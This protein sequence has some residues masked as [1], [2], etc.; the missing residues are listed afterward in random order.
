MAR[1]FKFTQDELKRAW[2]LLENHRNGRDA[3]AAASFILM[4]ENGLTLRQA[5]AVFRV[6]PKT[7]SQDISKIRKGEV[8]AGKVWGG[9]NNR[10]MT[11]EEEARFLEGF[12][13]KARAGQSMTLPELHREYNARVGKNTPKSTFYRMIK[14]HGFAIARPDNGRPAGDPRDSGDS[15]ASGCSGGAHK[16]HSN[17]Q[18]LK[19]DS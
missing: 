12:A 4:A 2:D 5:A 8:N 7:V 19:L 15:A 17:R 13:A 9:G 6:S 3:R 1:P 11:P 14:R 16:K 10:L 18:R